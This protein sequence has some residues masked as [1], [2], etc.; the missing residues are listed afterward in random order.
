M[1]MHEELAEYTGVKLAGIAA[2]DVAQETEDGSTRTPS[3]VQSFAF[4]S[5]PAY[6]LLLDAV[7]N[8]WRAGLTPSQDLGCLRQDALGLPLS[9]E[10]RDAARRR[11]RAYGS[12]ELRKREPAR[13]EQR[14]TQLAGYRARLVD[15]PVLVLPL[16]GG[17]RYS[18]DP[19]M[20]VPLGD[21]G[22]VFPT[23]RLIAPWGMLE[24]TEGGLLVGPGWEAVRV[25]APTAVGEDRIAGDGWEVD[26]APGWAVQ[27]ADRPGNWVLIRIESPTE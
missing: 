18:Y 9:A 26:L 21:A 3:F 10:A 6:G 8:V 4:V 19:S 13:R 17:A 24:V 22:T 27:Q 20:I 12:D 15:G 5:G 2:A 16:A 14:E 1:E 7:C 23:I 25:P 11:A